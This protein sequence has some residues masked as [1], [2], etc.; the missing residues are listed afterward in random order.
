MLALS[1]SDIQ[2]LITIQDAIEGVKR[3]F[4]ALYQGQ[5]QVPLRLQVEVE[6]ETATTLIMPAYVPDQ[7]SLGFKVISIFTRN[8]ER[9]LPLA[10][11][12]V[13]LLDPETGVPLALLNGPYLTAL[14]TGAVS[15]ASAELMS[16]QDASRLA[17]IGSGVQALYQVAAVCAV[18]T[19]ETITVVYR[20]RASFDALRERMADEY[21]DLLGKLKGTDDGEAAVRS[22][23][24]VCL[25]T[26]SSTPVY[27]DAWIAA[28][29]HISG[30]GSFT[31][32]MQEAPAETIRRA[33]VAVDMR[34]HA[35]AEAGD[36]IIPLRNGDICEDHI[37]A[38]LGELV[39][40]EVPGRENDQ[41]VTFFKSVGNAVQDMVV[42]R[43]AYDRAVERGIGN[44]FS[45]D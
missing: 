10:T 3:G 19:I 30:I 45:L 44:E 2:S 38:E 12:M 22:A 13:C 23:D 1:K 28:G 40:G 36:L 35:L 21:P 11:A 39:L 6:P 15:G 25:A 9:G 17:V 43:L 20:S 41:Q 33:R 34:E 37:V 8:R 31:P 5:A 24:I 18:R 42:A 32:E 29:T 16:R 4:A 26:T 7:K 27:D 14:R